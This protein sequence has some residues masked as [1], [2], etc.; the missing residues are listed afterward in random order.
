MTDHSQKLNQQRMSSPNHP[1]RERVEGTTCKIG[2]VDKD[3]DVS[4]EL[5]VRR[6]RLASRTFEAFGF[7]NKAELV[8]VIDTLTKAAKAL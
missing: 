4:V 2:P 1:H 8:A 5:E 3:G 7:L 6:G